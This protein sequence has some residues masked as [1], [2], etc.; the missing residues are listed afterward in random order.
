VV[1]LAEKQIHTATMRSLAGIGHS[2]SG[3]DDRFC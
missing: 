2:F 3:N 1:D